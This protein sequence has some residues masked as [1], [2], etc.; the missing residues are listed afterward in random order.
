MPDPV[1]A[2]VPQGPDPRLLGRVRWLMK[3]TAL[4]ASALGVVVLAGWSLGLP[5]LTRVIPHASSM[6]PITASCLTILGLGLLTAGRPALRRAGAVGCAVVAVAAGLTLL[7][8]A[9]RLDLGFDRL[10]FPTSAGLDRIAT[11]YPGRMAPNTAAAM[12]LLAGAQLVGLTRDRRAALTA[13]LLCLAAGILG[14]LGLYGYILDVS[15]LQRFLGLTG[16]AVHTATGVVLLAAGTFFARPAQGLARLLVAAGP[17]AMLT[18]AV[19]A[20]TVAVPFVLGWLCLR[21]QTTWAMFDPRLGTALLVTANVVIFAGVALVVG[22]R[23][24]RL[25]SERDHS[26]ILLGRHAQMQAAMDNMPAAVFLKDLNGR[27]ALVNKTFEEQFGRGHPTALGLTDGDLFDEATVRRSDEYAR[28]ALK[29]DTTVR[30]EQVVLHD[31]EPHT[32]LA[33]LFALRQGSSG[34][35]YALCG[36]STDITTRKQAEIEL[37]AT[38]AALRSE[39]VHRESIEAELRARQ[40]DLKAF[41]YVVA[42]DLKGPLAAVGGFAEIVGSDLAEGVTDPAELLPNLERVGDGVTRMRLFID[43]LLAYATARDAAIH[44]QPVDLEAMVAAI[45]AE[46]TDH[47]RAAA[48][49]PQICSTGLPTVHADPVLCRQLLDNL[50]G[51]ALKY[52]RPGQAAS[53]RVSAHQ[54]PGEWVRIEVADRGIGI[55]AEEQERI[56]ESFHRATTDPGYTGTGLGLAICQRV[57]ERHHG[58]IAVTDNPGGGSLFRFT[59]PLTPEA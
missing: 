5:V 12:I 52:T 35:P 2:A 22:S 56:F 13:Q 59:L 37:A 26:E 23:A 46:R 11:P 19:L 47:L 18:R 55:P 39:L 4:V 28:Q 41:A 16:M 7:E 32:Y 31:D 34:S 20:T 50:I 48:L 40:A 24:T 8:Y 51:N 21:A 1:A 53:V 10:L 58:T 3:V 33:A 36:V 57:V 6:K 54:C 49:T 38:A 15:A 42:H 44:P 43:D 9:T 27:Y 17:S 45:I 29:R 25:E 14:L 30:F